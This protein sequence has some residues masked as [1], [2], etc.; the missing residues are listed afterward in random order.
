MK[1]LASGFLCGSA[2]CLAL[3]AAAAT[4]TYDSNVGDTRTNWTNTMSLQQFD[5]ALGALQSVTLTLSGGVKGQANAENLDTTPATVMLDLSA[6]FSATTGGASAVT[7]ETFPVI[8]MTYDLGA[9]DGG[10]DFA[11]DSGVKSG[12]IQA[13]QAETATLVS[14]L[15]QFVGLGT[16][17]FVVSALGASNGSGAGNLVTQFNTSASA[18]LSVA[19]EYEPAISPVPLP[20][21]APLLLGGLGLFSALRRR[22]A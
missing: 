2:L 1:K 13:T 8:D 6:L 11:G 16:I 5:P 18:L 15:D 3:P 19:Y 21:S 12:E 7:I 22:K 20:A 17:D 9:F 14:S 4:L 10:I